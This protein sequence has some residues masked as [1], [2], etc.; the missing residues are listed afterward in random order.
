[1]NRIG[2]TGASGYVGRAVVRLLIEEGH[3]VVTLGRRPVSDH[4]EHRDAELSRAPDAKLTRD[5]DALLHLAANTTQTPDVD[6]AA[7]IRFAELLARHAVSAGCTM[8]F[9]SSQSASLDAP[10]AYGRGKAAIEAAVLPH[11]AV[12]VRPGLVYGGPADGLFGLLLRCVRRLPVIPALRPIPLVQPIH[13]DDLAAALIAA[14]RLP[15]VRGRVLQVAGAPIPFEDFLATMAQARSEFVRPRI[16]IS[17][18]LLRVT[19]WAASGVLG[20]RFA[21]DRL[22]SLTRLPRM[23]TTADMRLLGVA[24]RDLETGLSIGVP[25]RRAL[26]REG[27]Q[28]ARAVIG[29]DAPHGLLRRYARALPALGVDT[30]IPHLPAPRWRLAASDTPGQRTEARVGDLAW[31]IGALMRLA[32]A[33]PTLAERFILRKHSWL[34]MAAALLSAAF[35]EARSRC[36]AAVVR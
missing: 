5:L 11:G 9:V 18:R 28:I 26:L 14:T 3:Q 35:L 30:P 8:V 20:P 7:E 31:R 2:V 21:P 23:D 13:V 4:A 33:E 25:G 24:P 36:L 15:A 19:L 16:P 10:S 1:M 29:Q 12:V 32:E 17:R 27:R 34:R 22:D 6:S